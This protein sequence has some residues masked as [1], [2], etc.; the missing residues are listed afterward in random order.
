M[1]MMGKWS[2]ISFLKGVFHGVEER[3]GGRGVVKEN[4]WNW[5]QTYG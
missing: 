5:R 4:A 2:G 1:V 3:V